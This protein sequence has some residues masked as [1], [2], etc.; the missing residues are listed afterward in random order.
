[1]RDFCNDKQVRG[2]FFPTATNGLILYIRPK[3]TMRMKAQGFP[4]KMGV[5]GIQAIRAHLLSLKVGSQTFASLN[6]QN[7]GDDDRWPC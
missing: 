2:I 7:N 1:M 5:F 3:T 4:L 6:A